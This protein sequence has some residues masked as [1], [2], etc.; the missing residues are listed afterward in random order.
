MNRFELKIATFMSMAMQLATLATCPKRKVGC[1]LLDKDLL[2]I[3]SGYNGVASGEPHCDGKNCT[4]THAEINAINNCRTPNDLAYVVTTC[5]PCFNCLT[6]ITRCNAD[7]PSG[8]QA[9]YYSEQSK[10]STPSEL[11]KYATPFTPHWPASKI[12]GSYQAAG[13]IISEF[14]TKAGEKRVVFEFN[15]YPGMLH[16]F[17]PKQVLGSRTK[18]LVPCFGTKPNLTSHQVDEYNCRA[19]QLRTECE[20]VGYSHDF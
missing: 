10:Y 14:D 9:I 2:I 20:K 19:C 1:I 13:T 7:F 18:Q 4:C 3:G 17:T 12:G 15:T 16:I 11:L 8:L 5:A 6:A